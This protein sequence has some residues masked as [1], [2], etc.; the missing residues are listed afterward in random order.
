MGT[1]LTT[2][3]KRTMAKKA[4]T[5]GRPPSTRR[6]QA[7]GAEENAY[8]EQISELLLVHNKDDPAHSVRA[9]SKAHGDGKCETVPAT[10]EN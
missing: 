4:D 5:K 8:V 3:N 7:A 1:T 9:V 2:K 10:E 6:S